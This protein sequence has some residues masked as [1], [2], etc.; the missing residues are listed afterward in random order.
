MEWLKSKSTMVGICCLA[1]V[2]LQGYV[3]MSMRGALEARVSSV[4]S[5][6]AV[7]DEKITMLTSDLGVVT[8]RMGVPAKDREEAQALASQLKQENAQLSRRLRSGLASK[9]DSKSVLKF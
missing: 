6:N 7:A 9:A 8:K 4:E 2:G 1:I 3:M 5:D